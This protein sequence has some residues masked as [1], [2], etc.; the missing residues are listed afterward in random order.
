MNQERLK[1]LGGFWAVSIKGK[2]RDESPGTM[3]KAERTTARIWPS[4]PG[5]PVGPYT[6]PGSTRVETPS[7][8]ISSMDFSQ[9]TS[10]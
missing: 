1:N 5:V 8:I 4:R 2:I 6:F 3:T 7:P 9:R 10:Y